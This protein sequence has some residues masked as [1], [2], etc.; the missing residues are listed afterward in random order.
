MHHHVVYLVYIFP[1]QACLYYRWHQTLF[2]VLDLSI[3]IVQEISPLSLL[4]C[5][6]QE[7]IIMKHYRKEALIKT[8]IILMTSGWYYQGQTTTSHLWYHLD[9]FVFI[10]GL[11]CGTL[12]I[13]NLVSFC[14]CL[15]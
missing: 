9:D 12:I 13:V 6:N 2:H 10:M 14:L 11:A 15:N 7:M 4:K 8:L 1:M 5:K 3:Y